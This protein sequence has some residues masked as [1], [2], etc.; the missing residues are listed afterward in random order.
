MA[1]ATTPRTR[2]AART[3]STAGKPAE[4]TAKAPVKAEA[5]PVTRF[6]IA[7]EDIGESASYAKFAM[8]ESMKGVAVGQLYVPK[9]TKA[10]K[11]LVIGADDAEV[12]E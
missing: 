12:T 7:L 10:V 2:S 11:V 4:T 9:G 3:R 1:E 6:T 5:T 8:P